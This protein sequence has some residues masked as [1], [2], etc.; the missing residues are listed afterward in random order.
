MLKQLWCLKKSTS[1]TKYTCFLINNIIAYILAV[2]RNALPF[3][4]SKLCLSFKIIS[5]SVKASLSILACMFFSL[6]WNCSLCFDAAIN[7]FF[8]RIFYI[9]FPQLTENPWA[10]HLFVSSKQPKTFLIMN[11]LQSQRGEAHGSYNKRHR[12]FWM[13]LRGVGPACIVWF[14]LASLTPP[15]RKSSMTLSALSG[16][17]E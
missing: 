3:L 13:C 16:I 2:V 4:L 12:T 7:I 1:T 9:L 15:C 8:K 11:W 10:F 5:C 6:L 14:P 17:L